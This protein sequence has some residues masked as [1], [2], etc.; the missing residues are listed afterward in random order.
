MDC[1]PLEELERELEQELANAALERRYL[2]WCEHDETLA[3]F[4]RPSELLRFLRRRPTTV[5]EDAV[6]R[7]LLLPA[8]EDR[9]AGRLVLY[10]LLPGLKSVARRAL[11]G[12]DEREE[13]WATLLAC[14]WEQIASYPVARRPRRVAANLL[15]DT[16]RATLRAMAAARGSERVVAFESLERHAAPPM[17]DEERDVEVLLAE[18]VRAGAISREEAE[19]VLTTRFEEVGL[20]EFAAARGEPYN[21]VKVRRQRAERRLLVWLGYRPVPRRPQKRPLCGA[22]VVGAGPSGPAGGSPRQ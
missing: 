9:N 17:P 7:A 20:A 5:E 10:A 22:R 12:A 6:L 15:L 3:R 1:V 2:E 13:L 16:L 8:A 19:L 11:T 21:R 18:A 14:V 4:K